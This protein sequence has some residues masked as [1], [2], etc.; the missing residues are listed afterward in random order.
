MIFAT[1][2]LVW[3]KGDYSELMRP[4]KN[5]DLGKCEL[6]E[7][8]FLELVRIFPNRS[9]REIITMY[10]VTGG[11]QDY[12]PCWNPKL[13]LKDCIIRH[14]LSP[15]GYLYNEA[16][17]FLRTQLRET[18]VYETILAVLAKGKNKLNDIYQETGYSRAKISVYMKNLAG[19]GVVK[20]LDSFE[21]GGWENAKKGVYTITDTFIHFWFTFVYPHL[22][23]LD[24]MSPQTFYERFIE[25]EI[26][27]YM[28][29]YFVKVCR[30]YLALLEQTGSLPIVTGKEGTWIGKKGRIDIILQ[31]DVRENVVG[32]CS[33]SD[34]HM[35]LSHLKHLEVSMEQAKVKAVKKYLFSAG[36]F[37]DDLKDA[38]AQ[39]ETIELVDM[40]EL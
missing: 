31:N 23:A 7:L 38:A 9:I 19:F 13:S 6:E 33:W 28:D 40:N 8:S 3:A 20:K 27:Y 14:V 10:G 36:K 35:S 15:R 18:S 16:E 39:D 21:T 17:N 2:D 29:E 30:E 5:I 1:D 37:D 4:Y 24:L 25:P 34:K 12:I 32:Y 26:D 22:T 11:V